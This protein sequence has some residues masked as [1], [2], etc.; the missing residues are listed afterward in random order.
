MFPFLCFPRGFL[1]SVSFLQIC[2]L[3][4]GPNCQLWRHTR[5]IDFSSNILKYRLFQ[6]P[7]LKYHL[8]G[9]WYLVWRMYGKLL[10]LG[11]LFLGSRDCEVLTTTIILV[12]TII[13]CFLYCTVLIVDID[14]MSLLLHSL[15]LL[16]Y[17]Y[18]YIYIYAQ[19]GAREARQSREE[20]AGAFSR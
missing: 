20:R 19:F 11:K 8:P 7:W 12:Y 2:S 14:N 10:L 3:A 4:V 5:Y 9:T 6:A 18:I 16:L 15:R 13:S 1:S 17:I